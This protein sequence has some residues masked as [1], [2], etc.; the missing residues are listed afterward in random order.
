MLVSLFFKH[1][2]Y[3]I[4]KR[5]FVSDATAESRNYRIRSEI[6]REMLAEF[7]GIIILLVKLLYLLLEILILFSVID[8]TF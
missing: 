8:N 2:S 1:F 6:I 4:K 7:I 3:N 5:L